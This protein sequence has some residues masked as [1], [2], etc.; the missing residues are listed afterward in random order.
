[1]NVLSRLLG[2]PLP[3]NMAAPTSSESWMVNAKASAAGL[4]FC[5]TEE[6]NWRLGGGVAS[7]YHDCP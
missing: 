4:Q 7:N 3:N 5:H 1:M 6:E 2:R